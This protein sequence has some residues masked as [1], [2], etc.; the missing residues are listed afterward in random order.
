MVKAERLDTGAQEWDDIFSDAKGFGKFSGYKYALVC[1]RLD[2]ENKLDIF[3]IP[4]SLLLDLDFDS[5][6]ESGL[7]YEYNHNDT[8]TTA[9]FYRIYDNKANIIERSSSIHWMSVCNYDEQGN[10]P[11]LRRIKM[12]I[13]QNLD[14]LIKNYHRFNSEPLI[15][16]LAV[17]NQQYIPLLSEILRIF[18][19]NYYNEYVETYTDVSFFKLNYSCVELPITEDYQIKGYDINIKTLSKGAN[20]EINHPKNNGKY[21]IPSEK[22]E[23]GLELAEISRDQYLR[24]KNYF[25]PVFIGIEHDAENNNVTDPIYFYKGASRITWKMLSDEVDI[26]PNITEKCI[27]RIK[28]I[29]ANKGNSK[30][31]MY[32]NRGMGG[33]T[34][35]RRLAFLLHN[36]FPAIMINSYTKEKTADEIEK[37]YNLSKKTVVIFIDCNRLYHEET[38]NLHNEL[39]SRTINSVIIHLM[40]K[41]GVSGKEIIPSLLKYSSDEVERL[42]E[43]L[44]LVIKT[45]YDNIFTGTIC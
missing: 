11:P 19:N 43:K 5:Q 30:I 27:S 21:V 16:V 15:V 37:L 17:T 9:V 4:W 24:M 1:D 23:D 31:R 29:C 39:K 18:N 32:Y 8:D 7:K 3:R 44:K 45:C 13:T 28:E 14:R 36:E 20:A 10:R 26:V 34:L 42:K 35:L 40:K 6:E 22:N 41:T 25:E 12:Q 2:L 33:T 38:E